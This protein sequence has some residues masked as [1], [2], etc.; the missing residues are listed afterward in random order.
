[1][2]AA[3]ISSARFTVLSYLRAQYTVIVGFEQ[4]KRIVGLFWMLMRLL[5]R[6]SF[7]LRAASLQRKLC[8][9]PLRRR[10]T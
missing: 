8:W 5:E 1:M 3:Q 2:E 10:S 7:R 6:I 9:I 4:K